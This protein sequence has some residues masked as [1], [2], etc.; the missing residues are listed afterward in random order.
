MGEM[1]NNLKLESLLLLDVYFLSWRVPNYCLIPYSH[2]LTFHLKLNKRGHVCY[3]IFVLL[4]LK[5]KCKSL[6]SNRRMGER[7]FWKI[8]A[9]RL[10]ELGFH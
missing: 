8:I 9:L 7:V 10:V 6:N 2:V 3:I 4:A 1:I 5:N